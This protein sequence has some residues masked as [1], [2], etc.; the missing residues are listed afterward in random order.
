MEPFLAGQ[1]VT[2]STGGPVIDGIVVD[3]PSS[4]KV[5]V[6]LVD[7]QRGPVFKTLAP[8]SLTEREEEGATDPVLQQLIRRTP[9]TTRGGARSGGGAVQGNRGFQRS[10]SHRTTGK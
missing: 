7:A 9:G 5:V 4:H 8:E 1:L 6:A 2:V 3:H 10:S